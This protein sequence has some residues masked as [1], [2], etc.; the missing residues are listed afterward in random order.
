MKCIGRVTG[1][2]QSQNAIYSDANVVGCCLHT[3]G[4]LTP[5]S[6]LPQLFIFCRKNLGDFFWLIMGFAQLCKY[7]IVQEVRL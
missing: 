2:A 6:V 3:I 4:C 1:P 5:I 7:L